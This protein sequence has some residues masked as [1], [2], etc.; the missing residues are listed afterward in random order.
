[1]PRFSSLSGVAVRAC[2][3]PHCFLRLFSVII[4]G[5]LPVPLRRDIP[6]RPIS[7]P[8]VLRCFWD[9]CS[10]HGFSSSCVTYR[11]PSSGGY[12]SHNPLSPLSSFPDLDPVR[13]LPREVSFSP[14]STASVPAKEWKPPMAPFGPSYGAASVG[15]AVLPRPLFRPNSEFFTEP[16]HSY[17]IERSYHRSQTNFLPLYQDLWPTPNELRSVWQP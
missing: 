8:S 4:S 16:E 2:F 13:F 7:P 1:M 5:R 9:C 6:Y 12:T 14:P 15:I 10:P 11:F 3:A 17:A